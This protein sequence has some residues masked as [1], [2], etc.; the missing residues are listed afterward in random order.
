MHLRRKTN[1]CLLTILADVYTDP[2]LIELKRANSY[3]E[4][5]EQDRKHISRYFNVAIDQVN[6][7]SKAVRRRRKDASGQ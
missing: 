5:Q 4:N 7:E 6:D 1:K 2:A 3:L